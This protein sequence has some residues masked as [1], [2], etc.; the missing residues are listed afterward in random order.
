MSG[1]PGAQGCA[2]AMTIMITLE[3]LRKISISG[4]TGSLPSRGAAR[5]ATMTE[6]SLEGEVLGLLAPTSLLAPLALEGP[7]FWMRERSA[8]SKTGLL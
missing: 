8:F 2:L 3:T 4:R 1:L 7:D 6:T 5:V